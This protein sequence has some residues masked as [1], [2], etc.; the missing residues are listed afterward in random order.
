MH[1]ELRLSVSPLAWVSLCVSV[2]LSAP[3][4]ALFEP[5]EIAAVSRSQSTDLFAIDADFTIKHYFRSPRAEQ[6]S[7]VVPLDGLGRD[8]AAVERGDGNFEVFLVGMGGDVWSNLQLG[9]ARWR[10]FQLM[11]FHCKR[12]AVTRTRTGRYELFVIGKDDVVWRSTREGDDGPWSE[13]RSLGAKATELAVASDGLQ[14]RVFTIGFDR[15]VWTSDSAGRAWTSLGGTV[16]DVAARGELDGKM[17]LFVTDDRGSV[18]QRRGFATGQFGAWQSLAGS[19]A[20]VAA[21][22]ALGGA[23]AVFALGSRLSELRPEAQG[24]RELS[25]ALPLELTFY[26]VATVSLPDVNVTQRQALQIGVRFSTDHRRVS[27]VAF[28][29]F[30]TSAFDT[31]FGKNT[32]TVSLA[33]RG[34]GN[35]DPTT[36]RVS[37]QVKLH[38]DQSLDVPLIEE[39]ADVALNLTTDAAR[40][41][42][43]GQWFAE[44]ELSGAGRLAVRKGL[45]PLNGML[46]KVSVSGYFIAPAALLLSAAR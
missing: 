2:L 43:Q 6:F 10:G 42:A 24:W 38:L 8:I 12:I 25:D 22:D 1:N 41:L 23:Q 36:G 21:G 32:T 34:T 28:P 29:S 33:S 3:V 44:T 46:C 26:G 27:V 15:A 20:H 16:R 35:F 4:H 18:W 30:T 11:G 9:R 19:A 40:P 17:T 7:G 37:L 13:W 14:V 39:D 5:R 31:P 45:S